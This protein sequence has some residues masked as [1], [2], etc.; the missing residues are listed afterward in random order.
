M[1]PPYL[2]TLPAT[3]ILVQ[4]ADK[5]TLRQELHVEV[6]HAVTTLMNSQ[7]NR[8]LSNARLR[9]Y[10]GMLCENPRITL[11]TVRTLN[12]ATFFPMEE[13]EL[14]HNCE[15]VTNEVYASR[16][17]LKDQPI[18]NPDLTPFCD[19]SSFL[20]EG[21]HQAGYAEIIEAQPLPA[22]WAAQQA[23]LH[24]LAQGLELGREKR[25]DIYI[26]SLYAFATVDIHGAICKEGG[27]L[28]A[29]GKNH[30]KQR[31]DPETSRGHLAT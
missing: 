7:R 26:D 2:R 1:W 29:G 17:D 16:P 23:E 20:K 6:P 10:Q 31:R 8:C 9:Q 22:G 11:E 24:A 19:R 13:G 15:E 21:Q 5:L 4:E 30:Q 27:L 3:A 25:T 18:S 14:D 28:M 12:L